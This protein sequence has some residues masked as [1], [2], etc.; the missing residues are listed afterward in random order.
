M[1]FTIEFFAV[2]PEGRR[3][4]LDRMAISLESL[5]RA[6]AYAA[7]IAKHVKM[8]DRLA[9][10]CVICDRRGR[11]LREVIFT[12]NEAAEPTARASPL[13]RHF[14]VRLH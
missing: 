11:A 4:I 13:D 8:S 1:Q 7:S 12:P 2:G 5:D 3:D 14:S 9:G 6:E 10:M